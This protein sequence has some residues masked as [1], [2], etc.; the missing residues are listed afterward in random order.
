MGCVDVPIVRARGSDPLRRPGKGKKD[1]TETCT[2]GFRGDG[3][4]KGKMHIFSPFCRK[5]RSPALSLFRGGH[6]REDAFPLLK[7][8]GIISV[9]LNQ[10]AARRGKWAHKFSSKRIES[11]ACTLMT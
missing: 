10:R 5:C 4:G 1:W 7:K 6:M 2:A 11:V 8:I 3:P 9:Y